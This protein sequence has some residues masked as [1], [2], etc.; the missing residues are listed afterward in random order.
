MARDNGFKTEVVK[1]EFLNRVVLTKHCG[2]WK[3]CAGT[4]ICDINAWPHLMHMEELH[5][6]SPRFVLN[7]LFEFL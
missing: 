1:A 6:M 7:L 4:T 5:Q 2:V 3:Y